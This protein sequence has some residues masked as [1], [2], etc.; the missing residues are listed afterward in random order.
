MAVSSV[1]Q[2]KKD[3][4]AGLDFIFEASPAEL[5]AENTNTRHITVNAKI[6]FK[7]MAR[8]ANYRIGLLLDSD[9]DWGD[10][11]F[12]G[13]DEITFISKVTTHIKVLTLPQ[14]SRVI[15]KAAHYFDLDIS[16]LDFSYAEGIYRIV[17][18]NDGYV[19]ISDNAYIAFS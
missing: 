6:D 12:R 13:A 19:I 11:L 1:L 3:F 9:F 14:V 18:P 10:L 17:S 15:Q 8:K 5:H 4:N 2:Y 7:P 16:E